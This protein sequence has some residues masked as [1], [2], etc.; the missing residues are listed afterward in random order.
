[1]CH[2]AMSARVMWR[3]CVYLSTCVGMG[4]CT[5]V[6]SGISIIFNIFT[7]PLSTQSL[8]TQFS[9]KCAKFALYQLIVY[10]LYM[11]VYTHL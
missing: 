7:N 2:M 8:S 11:I 5:C 3:M 9:L 4:V 6:I 10:V 1:M